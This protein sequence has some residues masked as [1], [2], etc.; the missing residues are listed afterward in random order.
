MTGT[1]GSKNNRFCY[2]KFPDVPDWKMRK[3]ESEREILGREIVGERKEVTKIN[4]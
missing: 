4:K 1:R 2:S 3:R